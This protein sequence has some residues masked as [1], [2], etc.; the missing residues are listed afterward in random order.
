[1][2][3]NEGKLKYVVTVLRGMEPIGIVTVR[4]V[5]DSA[6]EVDVQCNPKSDHEEL[7]EALRVAGHSVGYLVW[8]ESGL[9]PHPRGFIPRD[10]PP[11]PPF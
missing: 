8:K 6:D 1:M 11:P 3:G 10:D 7:L 5:N 2:D 4:G 9:L